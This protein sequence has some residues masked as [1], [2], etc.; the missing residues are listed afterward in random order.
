MD[1]KSE[2]CNKLCEGAPRL[3]D[4]ICDDCRE[5]FDGF[6]K[7]LSL[8]DISYTIDDGIVRGLDYYTK[9]VFEIISGGFTVCGGGRYDGLVAEF[10]GE[11]TPAVGFG[12]GIERLLLRLDEIGAEIPLSDNVKL[13]IASMGENALDAA[14]KIVFTLRDKGISAEFDQL[15]RSLKAQMKY[16]DKLGA[17][18]TI[19]IG[20]NELSEG[21]CKIK[22]MKTG[23]QTEV[24]TDKINEFFG[25]R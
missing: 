21:V 6:K 15:G 14:Q 23:E 13:Y 12:L 7:S 11:S 20:D 19:V 17:E 9:S 16:A 25:G 4:Y 2:E 1:C 3:L 5:H 24:Q 18:Y 22:D 8:A 10:G